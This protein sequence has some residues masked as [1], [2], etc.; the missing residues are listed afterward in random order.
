VHHGHCSEKYQSS[1]GTGRGP[2]LYYGYCSESGRMRAMD[3][4]DYVRSIRNA[5]AHMYAAMYKNAQGAMR[6]WWES[7]S[8]WAPRPEE[9]EG[10]EWKARGDCGCSHKHEGPEHRDCGCHEHHEPDC[11][12]SCCI[13]DADAVEYTRCGETR[14]IPLTFDNDTRR[15]RQVKLQ[16]GAF[17]TASGKELG[18][19]A[20]LSDTDFNLPPCGEKTVVLKVTVDC[21]P[22]SGQREGDQRPAVEECKV[23]YATVRAEGC[24]VRPLVVAVAVLPNDCGTH[25]SG[26]S[27][28]CC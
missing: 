28:G 23:A 3:Y 4:S 1:Y 8:A 12:C 13:R 18:W 26:C 27:C 9:R 24:L 2:L 7:M 6:S 10:S 21:G 17:A 16:L 25:R 14:L 22:F 5:Y 15:E 19:N 11:H 20:E